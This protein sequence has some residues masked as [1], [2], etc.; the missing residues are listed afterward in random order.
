M[1][2]GRSNFETCQHRSFDVETIVVPSEDCDC[3]P[4]P[5]TAYK[6]YIKNIFPV[7]FKHCADCELYK[8][9]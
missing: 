1:E 2:A 7:G 9:R 3:P 8:H 4:K 5:K 6:C